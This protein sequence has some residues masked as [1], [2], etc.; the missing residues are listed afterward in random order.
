MRKNQKGSSRACEAVMEPSWG[1]RRHPHPQIFAQ[2]QKSCPLHLT[3]INLEQDDGLGLQRVDHCLRGSFAKRSFSEYHQNYV[4]G[5]RAN[6]CGDCQEPEARPPLQVLLRLT[7]LPKIRA[8]HLSRTVVQVL[9]SGSRCTQSTRKES[10][11]LCRCAVH[12]L[13]NKDYFQ[14]SILNNLLVH[15]AIQE[16]YQLLRILILVWASEG[17]GPLQAAERAEGAG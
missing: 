10:P 3:T 12:Q 7:E 6:M 15:L 2:V 9:L 8:E 1:W 5:D 13:Q 16:C 14:A 4:L 11:L 17:G